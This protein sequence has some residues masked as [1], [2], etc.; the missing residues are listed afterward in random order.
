[1]KSFTRASLQ[2]SRENPN[3][4]P[5]SRRDMLRLSAGTLLALGI[6]PGALRAQDAGAGGD[7]TFIAL[8][9]VHYINDKD[10]EWLAK[11][12]AKMKESAPK[13]ELCLVGGDWCEHGTPQ[14][15]GPVKEA[16]KALGLPVHGVIGNHDYK[17]Q[18][19]RQAYEATFPDQLNY[20]LEHRGWRIVCLDSTEGTKSSKTVI[21]DAT[22][23][24]VDDHVS[25]WGKQQPMV[26]LTHF[27]MGDNVSSRPVNA[28]AL[29][30]R[31]REYNLQA[32]LCGHY[33]AFTESKYRNASITTN[34]CCSLT[35]PNHDKT[36]DKGFFVCRAAQG[37][38]T[39]EFV[40][41]KTG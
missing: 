39:K 22:L 10:S 23:R 14:E 37:K 9:D 8:N 7:F 6:W 27:P 31:F 36:K 20:V 21:A 16:F 15:L 12:V 5:V 38:I 24:W 28:E 1:M 4:S 41:V 34:K 3:T 2:K 30:N 18:T 13:A 25:K 35:R 32:V 26:I 29:L 11:V 33:H 19:D 17:T 40:E